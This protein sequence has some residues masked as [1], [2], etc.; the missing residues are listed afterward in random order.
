MPMANVIKDRVILTVV[1]IVVVLIV[2]VVVGITVA[3]SRRRLQLRIPFKLITSS[4]KK[5]VLKV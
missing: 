4:I 3:I 5:N 1:V 2:V